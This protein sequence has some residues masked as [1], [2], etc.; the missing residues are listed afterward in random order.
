MIG[1]PPY[2]AFLDL[3][4]W[5]IGDSELW[6]DTPISRLMSLFRQWSPLM[7][8]LTLAG[9][10]VH[11]TYLVRREASG[12]RTAVVFDAEFGGITATE[13]ELTR[14]D[15]TGSES[16]VVFHLTPIEHASL[17]TLADVT[18]DDD[19]AADEAVDDGPV[20]EDER[21]E[22]VVLALDAPIFE[23]A[24]SD[25]AGLRLRAPGAPEPGRPDEPG[26][27]GADVVLASSADWLSKAWLDAV[28]GAAEALT[29]RITS[30]LEVMWEDAGERQR[31]GQPPLP[32]TERN[33]L[34]WLANPR[35]WFFYDHTFAPDTPGL[36]VSPL[37][38]SMAEHPW[39][40]AATS[41]FVPDDEMTAPS[42]P[43]LLR[44]VDGARAFNDAVLGDATFIRETIY[45]GDRPVRALRRLKKRR[46]KWERDHGTPSPHPPPPA[47]PGALYRSFLS[48]LQEWQGADLPDEVVATLRRECIF[49]GVLAL[50]EE[51]ILRPAALRSPGNLVEGERSERRVESVVAT[52]GQEITAGGDTVNDPDRMELTLFGLW[53]CRILRHESAVWRDG[54]SRD[55]LDEATA[56]GDPAD[57]RVRLDRMVAWD[58]V[59]GTE[60]RGNKVV[61]VLGPGASISSRRDDDPPA[62]ELEIIRVWDYASVPPPGARVAPEALLNPFVVAWEPT[63][64]DAPDQIDDNA[65]VVYPLHDGV[66]LE[67][68]APRPSP[69][70]EGAE[71]ETP[72]APTGGLVDHPDPVPP[73]EPFVPLVRVVVMVDDVR[74]GAT[75]LA[76]DIE[77]G[78]HTTIE[79]MPDRAAATGPG[80]SAAF[81]SVWTSA[82]V[83]VKRTLFDNASP[84]PTDVFVDHYRRS[85]S[86]IPLLGDILPIAD[87]YRAEQYPDFFAAPFG[88]AFPALPGPSDA[89]RVPW[90]EEAPVDPVGEFLGV[91]DDFWA[92][93]VDVVDERDVIDVGI[94][95]VPFVGDVVDAAELVVSLYTGTD[96]WGR[97]VTVF[98]Q[99]LMAAAVVVPFASSGTVRTAVG[100]AGGVV[101]RM[102]VF[103]QSDV[104]A[105]FV[106]VIGT[107]DEAAELEAMVRASGR[108]GPRKNTQEYADKLKGILQGIGRFT[109]TAS[110]LAS[111]NLD[112]TQA[113]HRMK[114]VDLLTDAQDEFWL[115]GLNIQ[116]KKW[117]KRKYGPNAVSDKDKVAQWIGNTQGPYRSALDN[118]LGPDNNRVFGKAVRSGKKGHGWP[119]H[120]S[121]TFSAGGLDAAGYTARKLDDVVDAVDQLPPE[122]ARYKPQ[123]RALLDKVIP[124]GLSPAEHTA[125]VAKILG[126]QERTVED[127]AY[128]LADA[129]DMATE[130]ISTVN[131]TVGDPTIDLDEVLEVEG[132]DSFFADAVQLGGYEHGTGMEMT[133]LTETLA[134]LKRTPEIAAAHGP[135]VRFTQLVR[136]Q[137]YIG[138]E[139]G[140]DM[141]VYIRPGWAAVIQ[142]KD[143]KSL[144]ALLTSPTSAEV[145]RQFFSDLDRL[146]SRVV[147]DAEG[148][149][150]GRLSPP[151]FGG[152]D[153]RPAATHIYRVNAAS[154]AE[155]AVRDGSPARVAARLRDITAGIE[156]AQHVAYEAWLKD[157]GR[158]GGDR[159]SL[160]VAEEHMIV[161]DELRRLAR[162]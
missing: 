53:I 154:M 141:V 30:L 117:L 16:G 103:D 6:P 69:D 63:D 60:G 145:E 89:E 82:G 51:D 159:Y 93:L 87:H 77:F 67:Y 9:Y 2:R 45:R 149:Q 153:V 78:D 74:S 8:A 139:K 7:R 162:L 91:I 55:L 151:P 20:D 90:P 116:Y 59:P 105:S 104:L 50:V 144:S 125:A 86:Q 58:W 143:V 126:R 61:L 84:S 99:A 66:I 161:W 129:M 41:T 120:A 23:R 70:S 4:V 101:K 150:T 62:W 64:D 33:G 27:R 57:R 112:M 17:A 102:L 19:E 155:S 108:Y 56:N 83:D 127:L 11:S 88:P 24:P 96:K 3:D 122:L 34:L 106:K 42:D 100:A 65:M 128:L 22:R 110:R 73:P 119:R 14:A 72:S 47:N 10:H 37:G 148:V 71:R 31:A 147:S 29:Q 75:R 140:P 107:A 48:G 44:T 38:F 97:P 98:D 136:L 28:I 132:I 68:P 118:L 121:Y 156:N 114:A 49:E 137:E 46:L 160:L 111:E 113:A 36:D 130:R 52:W 76:Y 138:G 1:P 146:G 123:V 124:P 25:P 131:R 81:I 43:A 15:F 152:S 35:Y 26:R 54:M 21:A 40:D 135:N 92:L 39:P 18:S 157:L 80:P 79:S 12:E 133:T 115:P 95:F 5:E 142:C 134:F 94:G 13:V 109:A 32:P 158:T 85:R